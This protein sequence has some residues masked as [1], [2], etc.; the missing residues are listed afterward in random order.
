MRVEGATPQARYEHLMRYLTR[1][2]RRM[3]LNRRRERIEWLRE[4][5][6]AALPLSLR[7]A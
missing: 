6:P 1:L 5:N 2:E 7:A 3:L 4:F